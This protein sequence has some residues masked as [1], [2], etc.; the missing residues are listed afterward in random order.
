MNQELLKHHMVS[1]QERV[2]LR[3]NC[4][5]QSE[6]YIQADHKRGNRCFDSRSFSDCEASYDILESFNLWGVPH[7]SRLRGSR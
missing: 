5:Q 4:L 1:S 7:G 2:C 6:G 3:K